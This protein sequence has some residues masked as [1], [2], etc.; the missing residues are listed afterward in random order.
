MIKFGWLLRSKS[1]GEGLVSV[2]LGRDVKLVVA[3]TIVA[4]ELELE[5]KEDEDEEKEEDEEEE[6]E[7]EDDDEDENVLEDEE[8]LRVMIVGSTF[9]A[10]KALTVGQLGTDGVEAELLV[11]RGPGGLGTTCNLLFPGVV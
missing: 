2:V 11:L 3:I 4:F 10:S 8:L 9:A 6:D 5:L 7:V 1:R